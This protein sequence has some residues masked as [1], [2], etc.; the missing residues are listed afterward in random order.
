[1]SEHDYRVNHR[2]RV[3]QIRLIDEEGEQVGIVAT[4]DALRRADEA[5]L[6]LVEVSPNS[7]PPV[8]RIMDFGKFKY[9]Q[10][11]KEQKGK[12]SSKSSQL[13]EIRVRPA[14]DKHDLEYRLE[15]A[16]KFLTQGHKVQVVCIFRGRQMRHPEHGSDVMRQVSEALGDICK[17][18]S[19]PKL[20]G[21]RMTML[22]T[23][24][25]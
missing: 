21:R 20:I 15:N 9:Q 25:S 3:P 4:A 18:E 13:K 17:I 12:G 19:A 8:C 10:Q 16:R 2:I 5:G 22:L 24:K 6:D 11:K 7:R 1:M 23:H 14:I